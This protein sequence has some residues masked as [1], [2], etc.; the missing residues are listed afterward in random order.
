MNR[1]SNLVNKN[2]KS[3]MYRK[4]YTA[5]T[6]NALF[7]KGEANRDSYLFKDLST[8]NSI[9]ELLNFDLIFGSNK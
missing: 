7:L 4:F 1:R 9:L 3:F 2:Y 8:T 6:G 5:A